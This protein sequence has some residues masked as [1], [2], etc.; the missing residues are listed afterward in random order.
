MVDFQDTRQR[1]R[2]EGMEDEQRL[3]L[4]RELAGHES[5]VAARLL[6]ATLALVGAL[7]LLLIKLKLLS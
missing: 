7:A 3:L 5:K 4:A 2:P 1:G 6:P